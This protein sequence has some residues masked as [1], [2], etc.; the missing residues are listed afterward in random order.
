M[1]K[2]RAVAIEKIKIFKEHQRTIGLDLGDRTSHYR[3]LNEAGEVIWEG[4][5]PTRKESRKCSARFRAVGSR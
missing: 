2:I 5:L 4:K 1:R 3:I